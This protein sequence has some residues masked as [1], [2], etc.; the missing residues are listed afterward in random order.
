MIVILNV[1]FLNYLVQT[2]FFFMSLLFY[3]CPVIF[4][5]CFIFARKTMLFDI[6]SIR[7][8]LFSI[9][10][11]CFHGHHFL[12]KEGDEWL[13]MKRYHGAGHVPAECLPTA[14][15][16]NQRILLFDCIFLNFIIK[17][18]SRMLFK[19]FSSEAMILFSQALTPT[20][21]ASWDISVT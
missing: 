1:F 6:R 20:F 2:S 11:I 12:N 15:L 7:R 9:L 13:Y 19:I 21:G 17:Q 16:S 10:S 18:R 8:S 5:F 4:I 14:Q 3:V